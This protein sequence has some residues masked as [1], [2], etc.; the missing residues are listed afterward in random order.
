MELT[1]GKKTHN[2]VLNLGVGLRLDQWFG[3][4]VAPDK[5]YHFPVAPGTSANGDVYHDG[6]S[7]FFGLMKAHDILAVTKFVKL[8]TEEK[9]DEKV[10]AAIDAYAEKLMKKDKSI[11]NLS[12][13]YD[14]ICDIILDEAFD[15]GFLSQRLRNYVETTL[16]PN[17]EFAR[18][19]Q[20]IMTT[21]L[22]ESASDLDTISDQET[23][24]KAQEAM[25]E[26]EK[27]AAQAQMT[28]AVIEG[29][30]A[31]ITNAIS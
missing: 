8:Y 23:L 20:D 7:N 1:I 15:A 24:A 4:K 28:V 11:K 12:Q 25:S 10:A 29:L 22:D 13:A 14:A 19:L 16:N 6:A 27:T 5:G 30:V 3:T 17:I 2:V 26:L 31:E 18:S 9:S 21:Q